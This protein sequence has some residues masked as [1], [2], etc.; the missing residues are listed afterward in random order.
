MASVRTCLD[1]LLGSQLVVIFELVFIYLVLV[2]ITVGIVAVVDPISSLEELDYELREFVHYYKET[3][4]WWLTTFFTSVVALTV[5]SG[6]GLF[7]NLVF[8]SIFTA[9]AM[10]YFHRKYPFS[11]KCGYRARTSSGRTA[12][13]EEKENIATPDKGLY[14]LEFPITTGS[15]IEDIAI[16]LTIPDGVEV[17]NHSGI[18]DVGLSEDKTTIEGKAPPGRD[19]FVFELILTETTGVQQGANLLILSDSESGR[20]LVTVRLLP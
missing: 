6:N 17:W 8:L 11:L 7:V 4:W 5:G 10:L 13:N 9:P 12:I 15:N 1:S 20:E 16:D 14:V 3:S 19:S 18:N 2:A